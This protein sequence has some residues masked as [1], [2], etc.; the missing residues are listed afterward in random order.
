MQSPNLQHI[1]WDGYELTIQYS[2]KDKT[3][4]MHWKEINLFSNIPLL[5]K[6]SINLK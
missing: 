5:L 6:R 2:L 4:Y 1:F 3:F